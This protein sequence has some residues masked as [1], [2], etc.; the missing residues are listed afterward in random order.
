MLTRL[1]LNHCSVPLLLLLVVAEVCAARR[2][3]AAHIRT[4]LFV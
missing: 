1:L 4:N 2:F 3:I